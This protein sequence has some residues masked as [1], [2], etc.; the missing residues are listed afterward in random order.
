MLWSTGDERRGYSGI[1]APRTARPRKLGRDDQGLCTTGKR[2]T[3]C[4]G[5][6][7]IALHSLV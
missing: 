6:R 7:W 1:Y 4:D 3:Q 2:T 5:D